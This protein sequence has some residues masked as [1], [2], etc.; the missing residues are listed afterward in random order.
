MVSLF[1]RAV[2]L[3]VVF[4]FFVQALNAYGP[5]PQLCGANG[6]WNGADC[7]FS[8]N[9]AELLGCPSTVQYNCASSPSKYQNGCVGTT[10]Y[11]YSSSI[12]TF[13]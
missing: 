6:Y 4:L 2:G 13:N 1:G 7:S 11:D 5:A 8:S 10:Y 12:A 3:F 9:P